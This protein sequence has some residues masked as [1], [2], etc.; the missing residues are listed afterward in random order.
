MWSV[1]AASSARVCQR[2]HGRS[3]SATTPPPA[4]DGR[5]MSIAA[6]SS[7]RLTSGTTHFSE[8]DLTTRLGSADNPCR[9]LPGK[10]A[11]LKGAL[12][13]SRTVKYYSCHLSLKTEEDWKQDFFRNLLLGY[14][15]F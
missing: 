14:E 10:A 4:R 6:P 8:D 9:K 7:Q 12:C 3:S 11:L 13:G 5:G 1:V 2:D 15:T